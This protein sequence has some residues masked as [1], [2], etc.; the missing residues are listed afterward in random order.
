MP[1]TYLDFEKPLADLEKKIAELEA[2]GGEAV[3]DEVVR[4]REKAGKQL[5]QI[6]THLNAWQKT[7][8]ARH[9][10]RPHFLDYV[11][12][13]FEEFVELA[14][15]ATVVPVYRQLIGDTLTPV[16][17]NINLRLN[18][19]IGQYSSNRCSSTVID[20]GLSESDTQFTGELLH[21]LIRNRIRPSLKK[22]V[23]SGRWVTEKGTSDGRIIAIVSG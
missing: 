12:E 16:S 4:L 13:L 21:T 6:Y 14:R 20:D 2:A 10:D 18:T 22:C 9:P 23:N 19:P 7:Q 11:G 15:Q 5:E 1:S 17:A 3:E 8:V